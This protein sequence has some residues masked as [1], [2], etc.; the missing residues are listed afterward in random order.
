VDK[1]EFV[2]IS[3]PTEL[4]QIEQIDADVQPPI[5]L[6]L[7]AIQL[8]TGQLAMIHEWLFG[9]YSCTS[10]ELALAI[11]SSARGRKCDRA[12]GKSNLDTFRFRKAPSNTE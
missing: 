9:Q 4:G 3:V 8:A 2:H 6:R 10:A 5:P 1:Q 11:H 7:V 12:P